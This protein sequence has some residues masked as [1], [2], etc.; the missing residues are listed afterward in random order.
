M[1]LK[2]FFL[3][4]TLGLIFSLVGVAL[5]SSPALAAG[6]I[7]LKPD[8][9]PVGEKM[10]VMGEGFDGYED[11]YVYFYFTDKK[12]SGWDIKDIKHCQYLGK[13]KVGD[14]AEFIFACK[15]PL[16][17]TDGKD[18]P[19][20]VAPGPYYVV[21]VDDEKKGDVLAVDDFKVTHPPQISLSPASSAGGTPVTVRG[22]DFAA[23]SRVTIYYGGTQMGTESTDSNGR[24]TFTFTVPIS[25]AGERVVRA[26]DTKGNTD[27]ATFKVGP[28][29]SIEPSRGA[30][31]SSV[32]VKGKGFGNSLEVKVYLGTN[33]LGS[34]TTG[35][36]GSFTLS[37]TI[38]PGIAGTQTIIARDSA[39]NEESASL[40]IIASLTITAPLS[41]S[42][43]EV[44]V[45]TEVTVTG[46]RFAA[47]RTVTLSYDGTKVGEAQSDT[48]GGFTTTFAV[49]KTT[50]GDHTV[51]A[52]D[53]AGNKMEATLTVE[54]I[55]PLAPKIESP[56]SGQRIGILGAQ[57]PTLSWSRVEDPSGVTYT[58]QVAQTE[59]FSLIIL[60]KSRLSTPQYTLAR[61]EALRP[62]SYFARVKAVD[63]AENESGW[64]TGVPFQ[65]GTIPGWVPLWLLIILVIIAVVIIVW[66][67]LLIRPG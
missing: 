34:K 4:L 57:T 6:D 3:L 24:F 65:V 62:G 45:G 10:K 2:A 51:A 43:T 35:A 66:V 11:E 63:G 20:D 41:I 37:V 42:P 52:D 29:L 28:T 44:N 16:R 15:V 47:N 49:P 36:D 23:N 59:D 7:K 58:I 67:V 12:L 56:V 55:A 30:P 27:E 38:P 19:K 9:G 61:A 33:I 14:D 60:T 64:S 8:E 18:D 1:R 54:S 25:P 5:V 26:Q 22:V 32:K 48:Q 31:G 13:T 46:A 17:T 40:T 53:G 39:G 21:A 50:A